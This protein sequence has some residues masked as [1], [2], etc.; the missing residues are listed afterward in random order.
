MAK[1]IEHKKT[2]SKNADKPKVD[3][4]KKKSEKDDIQKN[5]KTRSLKKEMDLLSVKVKVPD[6]I[7]AKALLDKSFKISQ[8][9]ARAHGILLI[10]T[11]SSSQKKTTKKT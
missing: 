2:E 11:K 8:V 4:K 7:D 5:K 6:Y 3:R 1:K 10:E 9:D